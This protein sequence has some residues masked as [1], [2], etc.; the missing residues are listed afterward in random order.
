MAEET[1]EPTLEQQATQEEQNI[2]VSG[3]W[4]SALETCTFHGRYASDIA[5]LIGFF[6][7]EQDASKKRLDALV[8]KLKMP[9]ASFTP[10]EKVEVA[11]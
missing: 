8:A 10:K 2:K 4:L 6:K 9:M 11:Q 7:R 5:D 3:R 1:K